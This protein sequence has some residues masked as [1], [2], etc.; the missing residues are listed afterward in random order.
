MKKFHWYEDIDFGDGPTTR[1][2]LEDSVIEGL[3]LLLS[4]KLPETYKEIIKYHNGGSPLES[5]YEVTNESGQ[6]MYGG[7]GVFL[8]IKPKA[9]EGVF[10]CIR[11][12]KE[13]VIPFSLDG[14]GNYLCFDYSETDNPTVVLWH[15]E[16]EDELNYFFIAKTFDEFL[17]E[18]YIPEDVIEDLSEQGVLPKELER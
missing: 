15:H 4:I 5:D 1:E 11:L 3:E 10:S 18:L 14:G 8:N 2:V 9:P 7:F 6:K 16:V 17:E 12:F 13:R